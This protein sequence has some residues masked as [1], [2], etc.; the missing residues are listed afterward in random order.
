MSVAYDQKIQAM[1]ANI[2][3]LGAN[4]GDCV[5]VGKSNPTGPNHQL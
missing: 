4:V 2:G 3:T 5:G 1:Q